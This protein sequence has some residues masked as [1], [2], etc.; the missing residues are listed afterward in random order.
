MQSERSKPA[1][2]A[3]LTPFTISSWTA[4]YPKVPSYVIFLNIRYRSGWQLLIIAAFVAPVAWGTV[5]LIVC[6]G[7][8][9]LIDKP[10]MTFVDE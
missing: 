9:T 7:I 5:R 1:P 6:R 2:K 3:R 4:N 10:I 8:C